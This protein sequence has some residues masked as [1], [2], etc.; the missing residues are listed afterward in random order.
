M[1]R[2]FDGDGMTKLNGITMLNSNDLTEVELD[3]VIRDFKISHPDMERSDEGFS[4]DL[5]QSTLGQDKKPVYRGGVT[6][7]N[8]ESFDQWYRDVN[9]VNLRID[10]KIKLIKNS[11]GQFVFDRSDY[12]PIDG[13][14]FNDI[15]LNHNYFFTLELHHVFKF[16]GDEVFTFR[17][18][19]DLW[20]FI[21]NKLVLDLGGTHEAM[22]RSVT[23]SNLGL[24]QGNVY[25]LD[26]FFAERHTVDSNFR[27]E[28]TLH[29][30]EEVDPTLVNGGNKDQ[31]CLIKS[32]NI[33]CFDEKQWWTFWC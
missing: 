30:E 5:V 2:K 26:L 1:L 17:G 22:E 20:V 32:W 3:V 8:K 11:A 10:R 25:P 19:D 4:T 29:L 15:T 18:D 7:Q 23:L 24:T 6:I 14:G 12:F 9:G 27:I 16:H 13:E 33:L 21:D 31:C 28:T